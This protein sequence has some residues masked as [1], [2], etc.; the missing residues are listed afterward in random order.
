[1]GQLIQVQLYR[2][3]KHPLGAYLLIPACFL[4]ALFP[5]F[6]GFYSE[7]AFPTGSRFFTHLTQWGYMFFFCALVMIPL[8]YCICSSFSNRTVTYERTGGYSLHQILLSR[9]IVGA[10]MTIIASVLSIALVTAGITV[11]KGWEAGVHTRNEYLTYA[12]VLLWMII[13][14]SVICVLS[15]CIA[16]E[17]TSAL[18][19]CW[20]L[21]LFSFI[22]E[23]YTWDLLREALQ[24]NSDTYH[25][26]DYL[27]M[28]LLPG[29]QGKLFE[30]SA[31]TSANPQAPVSP[32]LGAYLPAIF[33]SG[34]LLMAVFYGLAYMLLKKFELKEEA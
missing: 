3:K 17:S 1:M 12:L 6:W 8:A 10:G 15:G 31:L 29:L 11:F 4:A 24:I 5:V 23:F 9:M 25:L 21:Y 22:I 13:Q 2:F 28:A 30:A 33:I 16:R 14:A 32:Q 26:V 27:L 19:I 7:K 18:S 20:I 34:A